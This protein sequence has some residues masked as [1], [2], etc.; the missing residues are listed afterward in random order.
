MK[1]PSVFYLIESA[2]W[3]RRKLHPLTG[4]KP[5]SAGNHP[6]EFWRKHML[7]IE[8][9]AL[10]GQFVISDIV[11]FILI[12]ISAALCRSGWLKLASP[13][14]NKYYITKQQNTLIQLLPRLFNIS[15]FPHNCVF[16]V[17]ILTVVFGGL[18]EDVFDV[19]YIIKQHKNTMVG[20]TWLYHYIYYYCRTPDQRPPS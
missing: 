13:T 5:A 12:I 3:E 17:N 15:T 9:T 1:K 20:V 4:H 14:N 2:H 10:N 6:G 7:H 16:I 11:V 8:F 18:F 19:P